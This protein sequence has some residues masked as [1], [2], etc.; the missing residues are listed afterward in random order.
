MFA[1]A[2]VLPSVLGPVVTGAV[3]EW[4]GWRWIF[5][6]GPVILAPVWLALRPALRVARGLPQDEADVVAE[7]AAAPTRLRAVLPWALLAAAALVALNLVTEQLTV[8][9]LTV[10]VVVVVGV[11]VVGLGASAR[12]LLPCWGAASGLRH[13]W[14]HRVARPGQRVVHGS[15][16]LPAAHPHGAP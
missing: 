11:A 15:R 16:R 1:A 2:W 4:V 12:R 6:A 5:I 13:R 9:A 8:Q 14:C 7:G 3:T 10:S